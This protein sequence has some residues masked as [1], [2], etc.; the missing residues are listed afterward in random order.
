MSNNNNST[1]NNKKHYHDKH[2]VHQS[3]R[4]TPKIREY[5]AEMA[6]DRETEL[7]R[8]MALSSSSPASSISVGATSCAVDIMPSC[9]ASRSRN[10]RCRSGSVGSATGVA[11][12]NSRAEKEAVKITQIPIVMQQQEDEAAQPAQLEHPLAKP[13]VFSASVEDLCTP[14]KS[15]QTQGPQMQTRKTQT[16]ESALKSHKRLEWDPAADVGYRCERAMSTSNISTL[17]RSVLEAVIQPTQR[18]NQSETDLNRLQAGIS[19]TKAAAEQMYSRS[20]A[21]EHV[22]SLPAAA[23]QMYCQPAPAE[24]VYSLPAPAPLASSTFQSFNRSTLCRNVTP[25]TSSRS[26]QAPSSS[27]VASSAASSFDYQQAQQEQHSRATST[28]SI[29]S[30]SRSRSRHTL[31]ADE[32]LRHVEQQ[33]QE[34]EYVAKLEQVLC[35]R[36]NKEN[37][38][39][40]QQKNRPTV[41]AAAAASS[42]AASSSSV[43]SSLA[44]ASSS[45]KC[46]LDLGIDLLCSLVNKRSLSQSQKKQLVRDIAKRLALLDLSMSNS[47][48]HSRSNRRSS[49]SSKHKAE[50]SP[51]AQEQ[52]PCRQAHNPPSQ[53]AKRE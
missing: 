37:Q 14:T 1:N 34:R 6:R 50:P 47:S 43:A 7:E 3:S 44:P 20:T 38:Q 33:R 15:T 23:E 36:Q 13:S 42:S 28:T 35:N 31:S 26:T 22:Y 2:K 41:A 16:P 21:A 45:S 4:F 5:L 39:A 51:T 53:Q 48:S 19:T 52:L 9:S 24:H 29:C 40:N 49:K 32:L 27:R 17:E 8:F 46:D 11:N 18:S 10:S 30:S 25:V 12:R